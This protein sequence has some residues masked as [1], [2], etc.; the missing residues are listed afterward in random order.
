MCHDAG[1]GRKRGAGGGAESGRGL[2]RKVVGSCGTH[3]RASESA[4]SCQVKGFASG[5]LASAYTTNLVFLPPVTAECLCFRDCFVCFHQLGRGR[6]RDYRNRRQKQQKVKKKEHRRH[7]ASWQIV[8]WQVVPWHTQHFGLAELQQLLP[9]H[10][11]IRLSDLGH[12][13]QLMHT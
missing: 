5:A 13:S 8:P 2:T 6:C 1:W 9:T 4:L 3:V 11:E 12:L 7:R 10:N